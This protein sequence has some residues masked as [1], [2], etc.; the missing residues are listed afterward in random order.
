MS[1]FARILKPDAL[2]KLQE[3]S[4]DSHENWWKDLLRLWKTSG[5]EAGTHGLRLAIRRNYLNFYLRGQSVARVG[6][7]TDYEPYIE[8][9]VKFVFGSAETEQAYARLVGTGIWR[10][11]IKTEMSYKGASTL[12]EWISQANR[13][14]GREKKSVDD[15]VSDNP[16]I[17]DLEMGLPAYAERTTAPRMDCVAL[18]QEKGVIR[19][20]FWEA[21][22]I[23]DS[24]LRSRSVPKVVGQVNIYRNYLSDAARA[25]SVAQA[26][27]TVCYLLNETPCNGHLVWQR[28]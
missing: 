14:T 26:Y 6:F 27:R 16:S 28:I 4:E 23:D 11:K 1:E 24:R 17:I 9:H 18:E 21:K 5:C 3:L 25:R 7:S 12:D 10:G 8:T 22:M 13:H 2:K 20:V 15:L 19:I